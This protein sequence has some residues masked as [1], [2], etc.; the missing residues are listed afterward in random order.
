[1]NRKRKYYA[2]GM[3][4]LIL[5]PI[6]CWHYLTPHIKDERCVDVTFPSKYNPNKKGGFRF[7][8]TVLS[9]PEFK[10]K[11]IEF[12][13]NGNDSVNNIILDSFD[14]R[15][16]TLI[17]TKDTLNGIHVLFDKNINWGNVV[18]AINICLKD[19]FATF[20]IFEDNLW[21]MQVNRNQEQKES[22][23]KDKKEAY[24][25]IRK[26]RQDKINEVYNKPFIEKYK[27][28]IILWPS[29]LVFVLLSI[30][31]FKFIN[32]KT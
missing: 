16:Q 11:Y 24:E 23:R 22:I 13:L 12:V 14:K 19:T 6:L 21:T 26:N 31:S 3:I 8:T 4:S 18:K 29:I 10:R 25:K 32:K 27:G 30:V 17:K 15:N 5:L 28:G 2:P 1:M 9:K 20:M 7:D